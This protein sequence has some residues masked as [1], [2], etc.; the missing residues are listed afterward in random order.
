MRPL[1]HLKD[2]KPEALLPGILT[3]VDVTIIN[4]DNDGERTAAIDL[5]DKGLTIP[6]LRLLSAAFKH[7]A[8]ELA[9]RKHADTLADHQGKGQKLMRIIETMKE[10]EPLELLPEL[11]SHAA[12]AT[13][14]KVN[15][16]LSVE[17]DL[18]KRVLSMRDLGILAAKL[19]DLRKEIAKR[20]PE[21]K[22]KYARRAQAEFGL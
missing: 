11:A 9:E 17:L 12:L 14:V 16:E 3:G 10:N 18:P 2:N 8:E 7:V 1:E 22:E 13:L 15:G 6:E 20:A 4:V 19:D 5:P 21:T